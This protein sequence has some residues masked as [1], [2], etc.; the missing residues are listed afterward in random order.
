MEYDTGTHFRELAPDPISLEKSYDFDGWY[1]SFYG[2]G[3]HYTSET[4][5]DEPIVELYSK[6]VHNPNRTEAMELNQEYDITVGVSTP[7]F[8]FTPTET[9]YYEIYTDG[10]E[11]DGSDREAVIALTDADDHSLAREVGIVPHEVCGNVHL[12]YEMEA[13]QTYYVRFAEMEG[14]FMRYTATIRKVDTVTVRFYANKADSAWFDDNHSVT[15]KEIELPIGDEIS[16]FMDSGLDYD[17]SWLSFVGWAPEEDASSWHNTLLVEGPTDVYA[18]WQEFENFTL[19]AG[20][21]IFPFTDA[22]HTYLY[23]YLPGDAFETPI[24]PKIDDAHRKFIGWSRTSGATEPDADIL[25]GVTPASDFRNQTLYAVYDEKVLET[26]VVTD[27][28]YMMDN[29]AITTY[30]VSKGNGHIFYG[31]AVSHDNPKMKPI[32]WTDQ[33]G[34]FID[35]TSE[36]YPY[37]HV[38]GDTT[39]TVVWGYETIVFA[40]EGRFSKTGS[41][42]ARIR[43]PYENGDGT[44]SSAALE[45]LVGKPIAAEPSLYFLGWASD[46]DATE[47]DIIDGVTRLE[48]IDSIYGVWAED[49]YY[50]DKN[51]NATWTHGS[52]EDL[53]IVVKRRMDDQNTFRYYVN[54]SVDGEILTKDQASAEEGSLILT[55]KSDYLESLSD[56]EHDLAIYF[57]GESAYGDFYMNTTITID[58]AEEESE[59]GIVVP[60]TPDAPNT[61]E[62]Y[63][64]TSEKNTKADI[65][66]ITIT[67]ILML[68][69]IVKKCDIM[70]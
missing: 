7:L 65:I 33:N 40:V 22:Q 11:D 6:W 1:T 56:G 52:S 14:S 45:E 10:I 68:G 64:E 15:V 42:V 37:Y 9:A 28:G 55:L 21:G 66:I 24:D 8:K 62:Y 12:Y 46:I 50:F 36:A 54:A 70:S 39:Y 32:G 19:D 41:Q 26:F 63:P 43:L 20:E 44:F 53:E 51:E 57:A 31:M 4:V 48:D 30:Q 38:N 69:I 59:E 27:G 29:P 18:F 13:G 58:E 47:P 67:I 3:E 35:A 60:S 2:A 25:E 16:S 61:G 5:V 34:V 17:R 49:E 23:K